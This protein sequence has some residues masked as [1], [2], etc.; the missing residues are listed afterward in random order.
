[1]VMFWVLAGVLCLVTVGLLLAGF[2]RAPEVADG[3]G[4]AALAIYK[5]QLVELEREAASGVISP[6]E[7]DGQRTEISRRLLAAS[8]ELDRGG[9]RVASFPKWIALAVPVFAAAV[10]W[11]VGKPGLADVPRIDRIKV[12][13]KAMDD[14]E[15]GKQPENIDM[16]AV[17]ALI[18]KRVEDK[19]D[20][21]ASWQFL[22]GNYLS[23]Q[24]Y[25]DAANAI[26]RI[27]A[28]SGPS[29]ELYANLAE[30][31]VFENKGLLT[32]RSVAAA[33]EALKLDA[34]HPKGRYYDALGMAQEGKR[35]DAR[36]AFEA[37]LKDSPANAPWRRAVETQIANLAPAGTA[38]KIDDEQMQAGADMSPEERMTMI[39]G[40]VDGLDE[41]LKTNPQD[42]EG[43]L[44]II[45]ARTVLNE[46][47]K[48]LAAL[49]TARQTFAGKADETKLI[50]ALA[51]E[52][53][54]K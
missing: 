32:A 5:D 19:P 39:R 6:A 3:R 42:I 34:K 4:E 21:V 9:V 52:L 11:Q 28:I 31:L 33:K 36:S 50:D 14:I 7:A 26:D 13:Q 48:A 18:E 43:W 8:K 29:A 10:Y 51:Q 20:E 17:I 46:N 27:I 53:N 23:T 24:R 16:P 2:R 1:M 25:G 12:A 54:L 45:R 35:D 30:A 44:R 38:P 41:K 15:A 22:A 40:M 49:A 37:L 47:D